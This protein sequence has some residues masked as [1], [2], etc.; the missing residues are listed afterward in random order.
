MACWNFLCWLK[1]IKC[2]CR[3]DH[4]SIK[5]S[6][7]CHFTL[8]C[9][10]VC[11]EVGLWALVF[12]S[13]Y[14]SSKIL[15]FFYPWPKPYTLNS[16]ESW[17]VLYKCGLVWSLVTDFFYIGHTLNITIENKLKYITSVCFFAHTL[18]TNLSAKVYIYQAMI[19]PA[20][21][22][23]LWNKGSEADTSSGKHL[24]VRKV[25][26]FNQDALKQVR[27][28]SGSPGTAPIL[29]KLTWIQFLV[30]H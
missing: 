5:H 29:H 8:C 10:W 19:Y 15:V 18:K 30:C 24:T 21:G 6:L 20:L 23:S 13:P 26:L 9:R 4:K 11:V 28:L 14:K 22:L 1:R 27:H 3:H 2:H 7:C 25:I 16:T 12:F 17:H